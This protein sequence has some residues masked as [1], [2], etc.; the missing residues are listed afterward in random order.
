LSEDQSCGAPQRLSQSSSAAAIFY[1]ASRYIAFLTRHA[2][3]SGILYGLCI[4]IMMTFAV[5]PLSAFP[6][7]VTFVPFVV[8]ANLVV[9]MFLVG[10]P[11]SLATRRARA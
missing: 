1:I 9:H 8:A 5:L 6:H 11:I 10:L 2:V 4:Y 3:V 7:K